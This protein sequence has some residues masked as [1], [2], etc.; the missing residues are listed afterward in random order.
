MPGCDGSQGG[1][2][3]LCGRRADAPLPKLRS[4]TLDEGG[5]EPTRRFDPL[6]GEGCG[7]GH[8]ALD[9]LPNKILA[10]EYQMVLPEENLI[11]EELRRS[12]AHL[13]TRN[14]KRMLAI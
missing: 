9:N 4:R 3:Q 14:R 8:Y 12:R 1:Q 11:A 7:G 5:R 6:R 10:A 13:E 2:I